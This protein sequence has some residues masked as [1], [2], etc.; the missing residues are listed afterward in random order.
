MNYRQTI[1]TFALVAVAVVALPAITPA[2]S[3]ANALQQ[4]DN[5][6]LALVH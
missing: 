1:A 4:L 5:N 6:A 3:S 2:N